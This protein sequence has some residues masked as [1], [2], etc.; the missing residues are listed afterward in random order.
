MINNQNLRNN[1]FEVFFKNM[2]PHL[3][4]WRVNLAL[5]QEAAVKELIGILEK[6]EGTKVNQ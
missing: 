2:F 1:Y 3:N 5:I 6:C 4:G